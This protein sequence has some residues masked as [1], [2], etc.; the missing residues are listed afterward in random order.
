MADFDATQPATQQALDPRRLGEVEELIT[1]P[2]PADIICILHP[3]SPSASR[4]VQRTAQERPQHI[5]QTTTAFGE[6]GETVSLGNGNRTHDLALRFSSSPLQPFGFTFGRNPGLCDVVLKDD[7]EASKQISNMHFCIFVNDNGVLIVEDSS[8]NGTIV[9]NVILRAKPPRPSSKR[10]LLNGSTIQPLSRDVEN[11]IKFHVRI[12]PRDGYELRYRANFENFMSRMRQMRAEHQKQP[13]PHPGPSNLVLTSNRFGMKWDGGPKYKVTNFLGRGAF[14]N[15]YQLTT[16][17][18]GDLF[19][20]KELEK[21]RFVKDNVLDRRLVNE[22]NIMK[23]VTHPNIVKFIEFHDMDDYLY[24]VMEYVGFG[25]L[26]QLLKTQLLS[27]SQGQ[28]LASQTL[29]SLAY[30]H[31]KHITHRDIKPDNILISCM[32]PFVVKLSDFGLSKE[33][34]DVTFAKTFCGTLLYCAPEVFPAFRERH[35]RKRPHPSKMSKYTSAVDIWSLGGVLWYAL[36]GSPPFEGVVDPHGRQMFERI[37]TT[38]PNVPELIRS[39]VPPDAQDLLL[40]MLIINP[41]ERPSAV[42]CLQ[43]PWIFEGGQVSQYGPELEIVDEHGFSQLSLGEDRFDFLDAALEDIDEEDMNDFDEEMMRVSSK[44]VKRDPMF[45]RD[46]VRDIS[47]LD[48]DTSDNVSEADRFPPPST[49]D[50]VSGAQERLFGEIDTTALESSGLLRQ[51]ARD[52]L[53]RDP[54]QYQNQRR[55]HR[56]LTPPDGGSDAGGHTGPPLPSAM[57]SDVEL[58]FNGADESLARD[59][60]EGNSQPNSQDSL[61]FCS[62]DE[63]FQSLGVSMED[64]QQNLRQPRSQDSEHTPQGVEPSQASNEITPRQQRIRRGTG[65]SLSKVPPSSTLLSLRPVPFGGVSQNRFSQASQL[66]FYPTKYRAHSLPD[67]FS[68][69]ILA[70]KPLGTLVSTTDSYSPIFLRI[71]QRLTTW[72]RNSQCTLTHPDAEDARIAK[73]ALGFRFEAPGLEK[74]PTNNSDWMTLPGLQMLVKNFATKQSIWVNGVRLAAK[75]DGGDDLCGRL[76]SGDVITVF[77]PREEDIN[78]QSSSKKAADTLRFV[79]DFQIGEAKEPRKEPFTVIISKNKSQAKLN[80]SGTG[81]GISSS[82]L[83]EAG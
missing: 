39:G 63:S 83:G 66:A 34:T 79:C 2:D 46:Q 25:D 38:R 75:N 60:S 3:G 4:I 5:L 1:E 24:I 80:R 22:L 13:P 16:C 9:D 68:E 29:D 11:L 57:P 76:H 6:A 55:H 49:N 15:V 18:D 45:P 32:D 35:G 62:P 65:E 41:D 64:L 20:V 31:A 72:G 78:S 42:E 8:T 28:L 50:A 58:F 30:L 52:A 81:S 59:L 19:A 71:D 33:E 69:D 26:Q 7:T 51:H 43:H 53:S 56:H 67:A 82:G 17:Y 21:K 37:T 40:K 54:R 27:E 70:S 12:P 10:M 61:S 23:A 14:A 73:T 48:Q 74:T 47:D 36:S 77:Q 44:R